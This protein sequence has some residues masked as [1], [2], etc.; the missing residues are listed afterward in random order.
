MKKAKLLSRSLVSLVGVAVWMALTGPVQAVNYTN[1]ASGNW[2]STSV[3]S[4][5]VVAVPGATNS[6]YFWNPNPS[7]STNNQSGSFVLNKLQFASYSVTFSGNDLLFTN[8]GATMPMLFK[9]V[10]FAMTNNVNMT[11]ATNMTVYV[12]NTVGSVFMNGAV[13]SSCTLTKTGNGA[14]SFDNDNGSSF[15]GV[16]SIMNGTVQSMLSGALSAKPFGAGSISLYGWGSATVTQPMLSLVPSQSGTT[17]LAGGTTPGSKLSFEGLTFINLTT[18]GAG[19]PLTFTFGPGSGSVLNRVNRGVL[20]FSDQNSADNFPNVTVNMGVSSGNNFLIS[21]DAP[22]VNNGMIEPYMLAARPGGQGNGSF[23]TYDPSYGFK[24]VTTYD[25]TNTFDGSTS[26]KKVMITVATNLAGA[27]SA[28]A[29]ALYEGLTL[30]GT[31]TIGDGTHVAGLVFNGP[32]GVRSISGSGTL[33]F[34]NSEGVI[35][36]NNYNNIIGVPITGASGITKAQGR[37]VNGALILTNDSPN[38]IG[39][40]TVTDGTLQFGNGGT[41]GS[42]GGNL[43]FHPSAT[44]AYSRTDTNSPIGGKIIP[45]GCNISVNS[46]TLILNSSNLPADSSNTF[47]TATATYGLVL[48][49]AATSTN[50]FSLIKPN[51]ATGSLTVKSGVN[52]VTT[53]NWAFDPAAGTSSAMY[54][55]GGELNSSGWFILPYSSGASYYIGLTGGTLKPGS[56]SLGRTG[57]GL[58]DVYS[59]ALATTTINVPHGTSG[60]TSVWYQVGGTVS[61]TSLGIGAQGNYPSG[62]GELT[63]AGGTMSVGTANLSYCTNGI[64]VANLNGG[65]LTAGWVGPFAGAGSASTGLL[66]FNGGTLRAGKANTPFITGLSGIYVYTNGA[67]IDD[68]GFAVTIPQ[69]LQAP[70]GKGVIALPW[71][72]TLTGYN[73]APYVWIS[74]GSGTG[75]TAVALF[76]YTTGSVTGLVVT[77]SGCGFNDNDIV[78]VTLV[79][80]GKANNSLGTATVGPISSGGLTKSGAG[81]LTLSGTNTYTGVTTVS[82][83]K[84]VISSTNALASSSGINLTGGTLVATNVPGVFRIP[85]SSTVSVGANSSFLVTNLLVDAGA[86]ISPGGPAAI[87]TNTF[88]VNSTHKLSIYGTYEVNLSNDGSGSCDRIQ[89][90][91]DLD[92]N[93]M[94]IS[95]PGTV[96]YDQGVDYVIATCSNTLTQTGISIKEPAQQGKWVLRY[97]TLTT[98]KQVILR[99]ASAGAMLIVY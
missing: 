20:V 24:A 12:N 6:V 25:L 41:K 89:A 59:G 56:L 72:G 18:N 98:P 53:A 74:G 90:T 78:N 23:M 21:G 60:N 3:W 94:M 75:A 31:L 99:R 13:T 95:L 83:G 86:T 87:A 7:Y 85:S 46:G 93:G 50:V 14:V 22:E 66:N 69:A 51:Y 71:G 67:T 64:G 28:Y 88:G 17:T 92:L 42:I 44:L 80:G 30:N 81:T 26:A 58:I 57:I 19:S 96:V 77:C 5:G 29:V 27:A 76:D 35:Y 97:N 61:G 40:S 68:G 15:S 8:N 33:N 52:I 36:V 32:G 10:A 47:G 39:T 45:N 84:L 62:R 48:N 38:L 2:D 65:V 82:N 16:L 91:G 4:N 54:L 55:T 9:D 70:T 79:A 73:G 49:G 63:L 1:I 37:I 34:G 11:A 43:T